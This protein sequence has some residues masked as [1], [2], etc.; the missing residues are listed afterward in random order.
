MSSKCPRR[1][2]ACRARGTPVGGRGDNVNATCGQSTP[3]GFI[4]HMN[5]GTRVAA[6]RTCRPPHTHRARRADLQRDSQAVHHLRHRTR[7]SPGL[8]RLDRAQIQRPPP[9]PTPARRHNPDN[10]AGTPRS[11]DAVPAK[12]EHGPPT[13]PHP[14]RPRPARPWSSRPRAD[15][16]IPSHCARRSPPMIVSSC[17]SRKRRQGTTCRPHDTLRRPRMRQESRKWRRYTRTP[18]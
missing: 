13:G 11:A 17:D 4:T 6:K 5:C 18:R 3:G 7:A 9:P 15:Q 12:V 16:P 1:G 14:H 10:A 8:A 2:W